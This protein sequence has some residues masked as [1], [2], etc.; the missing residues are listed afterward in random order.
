MKRKKTKVNTQA[1]KH[2]WPIFCSSFSKLNGL[3]AF[4]FLLFKVYLL[5][6]NYACL[7]LL[8]IY[9]LEKFILDFQ[10]ITA[11]MMI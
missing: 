5:N 3:K 7:K 4:G 2:V 10:D 11:I 6:G 1:T 9:V 8:F